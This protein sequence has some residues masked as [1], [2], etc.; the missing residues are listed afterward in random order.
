MLSES[1]VQHDTVKGSIF[2]LEHLGKRMR[3]AMV[4]TEYSNLKNQNQ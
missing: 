1:L 4:A 2:D 3:A